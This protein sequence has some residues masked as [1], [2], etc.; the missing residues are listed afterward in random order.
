VACARRPGP[1]FLVGLD[2]RLGSHRRS[3]CRV[4]R[5]PESRVSP[6]GA[7]H[8]PRLLL[9][10]I[11]AASALGV[12][13]LQQQAELPRAIALLWVSLPLALA[14]AAFIASR[15]WSGDAHGL[16]RVAAVG[17]AAIAVGFAG[18]HYAWRA[19]IRLADEL[20]SAWEGRDI[21]LVG[22]V[23]ELPQTTD[24]GLRTAAN[25][26]PNV[27]R[28]S[29]GRRWTRDDVEFSMV[30]PGRRITSI[31]SFKANDIACAVMIHSSYGSA[32]L[33]GDIRGAHGSRSRAPRRRRIARQRARRSAPWEPHF[34]HAGLHRHCGLRAR[35]VHT[36]IAQS[37]R[38][39]RGPRSSSATRRPAILPT[40]P[41][42][43][44]RPPSHSSPG[45]RTCRAAS[46]S[47]S[48]DLGGTCRPA[49]S[50]PAP[51]A[52]HE[53]GPTRSGRAAPRF[54]RAWAGASA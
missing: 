30:H 27:E 39:A 42:T 14:I 46:A 29:V 1:R 31:P 5:A 44:A 34:L 53:L 9:R 17:G 2:F 10:A 51:C 12:L 3:H 8:R 37:P 13:A 7:A 23:D 40:A 32:L 52:A 20:P 18:F 41:A 16:L 47:R 38:L 21:E 49:D 54:R 48:V 50:W 19:Q 35:R 15:L 36:R 43:M 22:I 25:E 45:C 6:G 28:C 24:R 11:L 26:T 33:T 4:L